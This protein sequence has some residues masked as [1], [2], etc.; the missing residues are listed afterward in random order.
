MCH[1]TLVTAL[2]VGS[3]C[4]SGM[5]MVV[6]IAASVCSVILPISSTIPYLQVLENAEIS[7]LAEIV[8]HFHVSGNIV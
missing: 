7:E 2:V 4:C 8:Q 1:S 5:H 3:L 6:W